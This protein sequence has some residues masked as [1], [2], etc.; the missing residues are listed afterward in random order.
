M[1][2][3]V[4]GAAGFIGQHLIGYLSGK[5][6]SLIGSD[7]VKKIDSE[8]KAALH[9]YRLCE[10]SDN[11]RVMGLCENTDLV[12]H[13]AGEAGVNAPDVSYQRDNLVASKNLLAECK[14]S[15]IKKFIFLSSQKADMDSSDYGESKARIEEMIIG[16]LKNSPINFTIL[17]ASL[18]YG[19][20]MKSNITGWLNSIKNTGLPRLPDS[21]SC[22]PMIGIADLCEVIKTCVEN[23]VTDNKIYRISDGNE[24]RINEIENTA[25]RAFS[26]DTVMALPKW[27]LFMAAKT[28]DLL[29]MFGQKMPLNS[30]VYHTLFYNAAVMDSRFSEETGFIPR[31]NF[32]KE[33]PHIFND[34]QQE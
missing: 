4:T 28:G 17:R 21:Q 30:A 27:L 5:N 12:I 26:K 16:E 3:L 24:Y 9:E 33:L 2:I 13:L 11:S 8:L 34:P 23:P 10:L 14:S 22:L 15:N 20:G 7:K 29:G 1:N 18:V 32:L 19:R 6:Y 25:R 31:Q